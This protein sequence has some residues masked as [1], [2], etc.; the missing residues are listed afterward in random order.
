MTD[1][2]DIIST[3]LASQTAAVESFH[4]FLYA[5]LFFHYA[6][7]TKNIKLFLIETSLNHNVTNV[8]VYCVLQ[9]I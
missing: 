6:L 4:V 5:V 3:Y 8:K 2:F 1:I 7:Y 9:F